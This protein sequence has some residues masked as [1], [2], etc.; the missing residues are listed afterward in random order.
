MTFVAYMQLKRSIEEF[1]EAY[2]RQGDSP[3]VR[4]RGNEPQKELIPL[5][6]N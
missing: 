2:R 6:S 5:L 1:A 4:A 3:E